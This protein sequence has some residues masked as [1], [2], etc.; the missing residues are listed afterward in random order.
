MQQQISRKPARR[1]QHPVD[2]FHNTINA[3]NNYDTRSA[4]SGGAV[5]PISSSAMATPYSGI[6]QKHINDEDGYESSQDEPMF[7]MSSIVGAEKYNALRSGHTNGHNENVDVAAAP[8]PPTIAAAENEIGDTT[9]ILNNNINDTIEG[10]TNYHRVVK[11]SRLLHK[12]LRHVKLIK[13]KGISRLLLILVLTMVSKLTYKFIIHKNVKHLL[14]LSSSSKA[15]SEGDEGD[16]EGDD[17]APPPIYPEFVFDHPYVTSSYYISTSNTAVLE[18]MYDQQ[19]EPKKDR[20]PDRERGIVSRLAI[21]RPFCEFDAEPLPTTFACWNS[22]VPCRAAE[23]DLGEEEDEDDDVD[24]WVLFD[25]STNGTGRKLKEEEQDDWECEADYSSGST[26]NNNSTSTS[27]FRGIAN[28]LFKR[29]KRKPKTKDYF[30]DVSADGLR[31]TSADLFLFYSQ[32]FSENDVAMKAVD[33]IMEEFFSPG[34]WSR[35][36]DNIYAVEANIPKELDL[37]IP[38]A[39]EELYNWVNGPNRQY[40]AGFRIIQSGEWGDYDG[41]YLMEG[42]SVPVKNYWLDVILGEI[43]AYRPFAVLGAQ[44]DGDKWDAFYEDIPISLL[45]HTNGNGIYN[46]SHPLL[47]R[48]TGQLEVEAPCPYNSIPYDY[49]MSQMWVEG[50]LGIVPQLAPKIMLNEEGENITL[51]DNKAMFTKWANRWKDEEPYRFTKAIHNYAATNLIPRHLGPE[52]VIHGAKLYSPWDPSRTEVTLVISEWFFDRSLNLIKNLDNKDHPFSKVIVMIPPSISNS[53]D[54]SMYTS[55]PVHLQFRDTPDFMDLCSAEVTTEWFMITNSYHQVSRHVDLMFTP[56][57]FVP[58]IPFTPATYPFCLKFPYC[59]EII[60]LAQ[61]WNPKH[62]QVVLDMDMLYNTEQRNAFC[63]EWTER[64]GEHGEDLYAKHQPVRYQL[65][66]DSIIGP[67]GP[68]G[69]DYLAYLGSK[70]KDGM[71]KMTDR[72]LYGARPPFVK[73]YRKEEKLDGMS[74]DE[75]ARRLGMT[76]LSNTTE[77]SCDRFETETECLE[78]GLGCQ[79]RALFESCHPPEMIDDGVPICETTEAPTMSPTLSIDRFLKET[80]A[81]TVDE[82]PPPKSEEDATPKQADTVSSNGLLGSLFKTREHSAAVESDNGALNESTG[83]RILLS[84]SDEDEYAML[85][86]FDPVSVSDNLNMPGQSLLQS[87]ALGDVSSYVDPLDMPENM[88]PTYGPS[89]VPRR[90]QGVSADRLSIR[91]SNVTTS[92]THY[93]PGR[94]RHTQ[95]QLAQYDAAESLS[96]QSIEIPSDDEAKRRRVH[97][98]YSDQV[99]DMR[100]VFDASSLTARVHSMGKTFADMELYNPTRARVTAFEE[101]IFPA[102]TKTWGDALK[103]RP[104]QQNIVPHVSTCGDTSIS[105]DHLTNGVPNADLLIYVEVGEEST[106]AMNS[107]PKIHICHFD[108]DMRPLIGSL[109]LC[110]DD[111]GVQDDEVHEKETRKHIAQISQLVGRFL[112]LTPSLFKYFRNAETGK[113]WGERKLDISCDDGTTKQTQTILLSNLIQEKTD[114]SNVLYYEISSPSVKRIVR[115]HFDC[116]TLEGARLADPLPHP[117]NSECSFFHLNLRYHFDEDMTPIATNE[118]SAYAISPLSLAL[119]EDS[120]WYKANFRAATT[121]TFGRGAGCGFVEDDCILKGKVPDYSLGFFCSSHEALGAR[122][123][124]D[125]THHNKAGCDLN[126]YANPPENFQYFHPDNPEHGSQ[127]S[128]VD[129]CPMRSKHLIPCSSEKVTSTL[130][131]ESFE[132]N[133]RCYETDAGIPVCLETTCNPL[134]RTLSFFVEGK[135]F[136]CTY[137]GQ[138]INVD[139]GYSVVCP[140]IAAVCPD[141]VCPSNC[142]GK[143]TCDYCQEVPTCVCDDPFD[144]SEGCFES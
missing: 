78:S 43:N 116:Q 5:A 31:T 15:K 118:D 58:V 25:M 139:I 10:S 111:L 74:E 18:K 44:Y 132:E 85:K 102:V 41:F 40:E 29:C 14:K 90:L 60:H 124:C 56:G 143:G 83:N 62:K 42:D 73:V 54:Y 57:K 119:L 84:V 52:Y 131:G 30:D 134:E 21:L 130:V 88:C 123:G 53:H 38:A 20:A 48:L 24:E 140:R 101:V 1:R 117:D 6:I 13:P 12:K 2:A 23:Q 110:I 47:E 4:T 50:T 96:A 32:T 142:S 89:V 72:S 126:P 17:D 122:S 75:L 27:F 63:K 86:N 92:A 97:V 45:H 51:S 121:P 26:T 108:Q 19:V 127:H 120:S 8:A 94:A 33:K 81:P 61:R 65:R 100:L 71:Y 7:G 35:C 106:C 133:S 125:Y 11:S 135:F 79:W 113:L 66:G 39:Q 112:G 141:L 138:V 77:C 104:L 105:E 3:I 114:D 55:V 109:T 59:K 129:Y 107:M 99:Q 16:G 128:D 22:L 28:S 67:K 64:N 98:E 36:F 103:I 34:G 80:D 9:T 115:N 68:T 91:A 95:H 93:M 82:A 49:R 144:Q 87:L 69:S 46:V 136:H 37:Y 137:H 76:L 70:K